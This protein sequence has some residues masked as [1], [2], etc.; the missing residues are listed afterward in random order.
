MKDGAG[1]QI[2]P[3]G[4]YEGRMSVAEGGCLVLSGGNINILDDM[5]Y[6]LF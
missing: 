4:E 2:G 6:C 5:R 3:T 1:L